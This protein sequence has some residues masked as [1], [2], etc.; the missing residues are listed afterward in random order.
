LAREYQSIHTYYDSKSKHN[1]AQDGFIANGRDLHV[2]QL[3]MANALHVP[4]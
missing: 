2:G 3:T 1:P 4:S